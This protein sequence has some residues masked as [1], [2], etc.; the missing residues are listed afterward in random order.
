[1]SLVHGLTRRV[2]Q[3]LKDQEV[4][5]AVI[6]IG[7]EEEPLLSSS[8]AIRIR[9]AEPEKLLLVGEALAVSVALA[10]DE[11]RIAAAF[12]KIEPVAATLMK[13]RLPPGPRS[14]CWSR[15]GRRF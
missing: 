10:Y 4:E 1:M 7:P 12:E 13:R 15:S 2:I 14:A 6:A 9:S 3:P 11:R 5:T 8:G